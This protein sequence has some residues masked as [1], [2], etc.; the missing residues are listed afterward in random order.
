MKFLQ[1]IQK[2]E[3]SFKDVL[4]EAETSHASFNLNKLKRL[5][6]LVLEILFFLLKQHTLTR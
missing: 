2:H 3:M 1:P 4:Q 6:V 5:R